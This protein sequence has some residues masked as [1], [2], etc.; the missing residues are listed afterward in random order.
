M[1]ILIIGLPRCG[2]TALAKGLSES[3]NLK[4]F[5]EPWNI[6]KHYTTFPYP[7]DFGENC[8][9]KTLIEQ[10]PVEVK[11]LNF[12]EYYN[13]LSNDFDKIILLGRKNL[14]DVT[15]SYTYQ[16]IEERNNSNR[17]P[18]DW[19]KPYIPDIEEK[20]LKWNRPIINKK[21]EL[22]GKLSKDLQVP[23]TWYEDLFSGNPKYVNSFL[24][25]LDIDIDRNK[26]YLFLDPK[27]KLRKTNSII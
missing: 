15:I 16:L 1:K 20:E 10:I 26:L 11:D 18:Q 13:R 7:Y 21:N 27:N 5:L 9:V 14:E 22:L 2:T 3:C 24:D 23:I 6:S 17:I 8:I 25:N 4:K 19:Q 12:L